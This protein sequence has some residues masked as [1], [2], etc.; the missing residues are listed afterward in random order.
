M[1]TSVGY[2]ATT[3]TAA[4]TV[5]SFSGF[6]QSLSSFLPLFLFFLTELIDRVV[7]LA[8]PAY[9]SGARGIN[10]LNDRRHG[11]RE[12]SGSLTS[13]SRDRW[14]LA[15]TSL[16]VD[17]TSTAISSI[18]VS[19]LPSSPHHF[20]SS[21]TWSSFSFLFL[22][23]L[24]ISSKPRAN[25]AT[26][27]KLNCYD[28]ADREGKGKGEG[29]GRPRRFFLR[30][31]FHIACASRPMIVHTYFLLSPLNMKRKQLEGRRNKSEENEKKFNWQKQIWI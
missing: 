24:A 9:R 4:G 22:F 6:F 20:S 19:P 31:I 26:K 2:H 18:C 14:R 12:W 3:E 28:S 11:R 1:D 17:S 29:E 23:T 13:R 25:S 5:I 15:S 8:Y 21:D 16:G 30:R 27:K 7:S 10:K